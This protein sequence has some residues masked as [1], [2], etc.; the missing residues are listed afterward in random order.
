LLAAFCFSRSSERLH[1]WLTH[2]P[3]YGPHIQDWKRSGAIQPK[4]KRMATG[5]I[6]AAFLLSVVFGV[7]AQILLIQAVVLLG[8]LSFIW[9]RPDH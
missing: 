5:M 1:L 6:A 2:H 3:V 7:K 4:A 8:V 9:T